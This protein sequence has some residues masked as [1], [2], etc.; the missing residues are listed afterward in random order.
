MVVPLL[1]TVIILLQRTFFALRKHLENI[2]MI[3]E[4][5]LV[6]LPLLGGL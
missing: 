5:T 1:W 3:E 2:F 6:S 4:F